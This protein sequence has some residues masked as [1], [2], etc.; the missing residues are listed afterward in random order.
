[1]AGRCSGVL[2]CRLRALG[3][4]VA[5]CKQGESLRAA[6]LEGVVV[7]SAT[8]STRR[9]GESFAR[10]RGGRLL[11]LEVWHAGGRPVNQSAPVSAGGR[12]RTSQRR[13]SEMTAAAWGNRNTCS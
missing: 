10:M 2:P 13:S 5:G 8:S 4:R 9:P 7:L 3:Q 11:P 6:R 12:G 1:S